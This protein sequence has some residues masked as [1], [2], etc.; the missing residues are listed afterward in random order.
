MIFQMIKNNVPEKYF[1]LYIVELDCFLFT[2][3]STRGESGDGV[4]LLKIVISD[5]K[6]S[7]VID[8]QDLEEKLASATFQK[9]EKKRTFLHEGYG[10]TIQGDQTLEARN[11]RRQPLSHSIVS[12][13][14]NNN[15]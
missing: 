6:P 1:E 7:T 5:I 15:T 2:D 11:I 3:N 12:R 4:I 10:E 13:V 9:N 8:V 14:R